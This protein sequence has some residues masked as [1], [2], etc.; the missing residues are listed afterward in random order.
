MGV[1]RVIIRNWKKVEAG[2]EGFLKKKTTTTN[3]K[4]NWMGK[5]EEW[6]LT[7]A[8]EDIEK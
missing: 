4:I 1:G 8:E 7:Q 3:G 6:K 2:Y 5:D